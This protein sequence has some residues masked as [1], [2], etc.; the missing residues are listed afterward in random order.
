MAEF[1]LGELVCTAGVAE[2]GYDDAD[3]REFVFASLERYKSCDWGELDKSDKKL[4]DHA[5]KDGEERILAAYEYPDKPDWKIWIITEWDH[6]YTTILL[7][8]EY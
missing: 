4:N 1:K 6:N 8:H 5:V 7:P 2:L 3:F